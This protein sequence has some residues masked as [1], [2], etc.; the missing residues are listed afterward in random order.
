MDSKLLSTIILTRIGFL[1]NKFHNEMCN[2]DK[3]KL[4]KELIINRKFFLERKTSLI[5][6]E[7]IELR[8]FDREL[9]IIEKKKQTYLKRK[10]SIEK[11]IN[12]EKKLLTAKKVLELKLFV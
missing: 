6:R 1:K 7:K 2:L 8:Y 9:N 12:L 10:N 4:E 5:D 11:K 3:L